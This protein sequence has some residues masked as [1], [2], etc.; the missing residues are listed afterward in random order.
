MYNPDILLCMI[1]KKMYR[2]SIK[3]VVI[4]ENGK[5]LLTKEDN[6]KWE[7]LGGGIEPNEDALT[8]LEREIREE[9]GLSITRASPHP[10]Y[11]VTSQKANGT[12]IANIIYGIEL[13]S[14]DFTPSEE[15]QE[16]RFFSPDEAMKEELF[17]N[18]TEFIKQFS[19][20]LHQF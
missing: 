19:P 4:N 10:I 5:F 6:G 15:C 3:G 20:K 18:V 8:C 12:Q 16:L 9:T 2:I 13:E 11:F 7:L 17:P 1:D 14:L